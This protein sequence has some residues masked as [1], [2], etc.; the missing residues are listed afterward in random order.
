MIV[1]FIGLGNLGQ[2]LASTLSRNGVNLIVNDINETKAQ[3]L[4][5]KG[6]V[7]A[8]TPQLVAEQSDQII[9][10]LPSPRICADVM[11]SENGVIAGLTEGKIWIEMSTTSKFE[12]LRLNDKISEKGAVSSDCPVSGGCHKAASGNVSIF[13]GCERE[14]FERIKTTLF[15]MGKKILHTGDLGTASVLKVMTNYLA[16]ANLISCCEALT[17]MKSAG[18]DLATTFEAIKI[19]SGNSF[20]HETESQVILNGSRDINFT[21]GL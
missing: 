19:S 3:E 17:T 10:C 7:W 5:K 16:T 13:S 15:I 14:V 9:T 1:G 11:E 12:V 20:V 6:A 4:I 18:L 21:M 8:K 2:K